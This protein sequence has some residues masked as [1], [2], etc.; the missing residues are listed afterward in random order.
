[1]LVYLTGY[2]TYEPALYVFDVIK[3]GDGDKLRKCGLDEILSYCDKLGIE[4]VPIEETGDSFHY[5]LPELIERAKGKYV[6]GL[7]KEGIVV[8][9]REYGRIG[10]DKLSFKV[11]NNDFLAKEKD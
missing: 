5:T 1:M 8:R 9:T 10:N 7:D 11:I 4:S 3:I 2:S 6:S